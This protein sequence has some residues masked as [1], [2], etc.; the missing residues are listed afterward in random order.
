MKKIGMAKDLQNTDNV[1]SE[2]EEGL[3]HVHDINSTI[4]TTVNQFDFAADDDALDEELNEILGLNPAPKQVTQPIVAGTAPTMDHTMSETRVENAQS[5]DD[6]EARD[7][8][9]VAITVT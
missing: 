4:G 6:S 8:N 3:Q 5:L 7:D 9:D 2:L 1:I